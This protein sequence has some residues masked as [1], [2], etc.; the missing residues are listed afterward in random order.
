MEPKVGKRQISPQSVL[1]LNGVY[2]L[3]YVGRNQTGQDRIGLAFSNDGINWMKYSGNPVLVPSQSWEGT[4]V[5]WPG[6]I[7]ENGIFIMIYMKVSYESNAFGMAT[8]SDGKN[9]I[10]SDANPIFKSENTSNGWAL[11]DIAYP[12]FVKAGNEYRI[13]YSGWNQNKYKIGFASKHF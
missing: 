10:K 11:Y 6:V 8:S 4:G 7:N 5:S 9:W 12:T 2:Y 3:Y 1:K 13:Y